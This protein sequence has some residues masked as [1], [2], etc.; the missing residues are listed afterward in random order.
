MISKAFIIIGCVLLV[1][2]QR[3][4]RLPYTDNNVINRALQDGTTLRSNT[5][6]NGRR[7]QSDLLSISGRNGP[8]VGSDNDLVTYDIKTQPTCREIKRGP[9]GSRECGWNAGLSRNVDQF[10]LNGRIAAYKIQWEHGSWSE[11]YVPGVNDIDIKFNVQTAYCRD[12]DLRANSMRR[13]WAYF[14]EY[15]HVVILCEDETKKI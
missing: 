9:V 5:L 3:S 10:Y 8:I 4:P 11:W 2:A 13:W 15:T 14:N 1:S 6:L 7:Q 12:Y